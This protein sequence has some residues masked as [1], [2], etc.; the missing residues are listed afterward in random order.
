MKEFRQLLRKKY[1]YDEAGRTRKFL[2][3]VAIIWLLILL[4][5]LVAAAEFWLYDGRRSPEFKVFLL[6][7]IVCIAIYWLC[8]ARDELV[9]AGDIKIIVTI[10]EGHYKKL[11]RLAWQQDTTVGDVFEQL[12]DSTVNSRSNQFKSSSDVAKNH[13]SMLHR[14]GKNRVRAG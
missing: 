9:V 1:L 13:E 7:G 3:L 11:K 5:S 8:F 14:W 12:M 2:R 10:S 6:G 4:A